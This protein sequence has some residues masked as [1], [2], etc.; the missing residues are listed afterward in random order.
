LKNAGQERLGKVLSYIGKEAVSGTLAKRS[1]GITNARIAP[2]DEKG[3]ELS[4]NDLT[5]W[6]ER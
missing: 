2:E 1:S 4:R 5:G 3:A 6:G